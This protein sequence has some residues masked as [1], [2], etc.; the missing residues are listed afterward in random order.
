MRGRNGWR[1]HV[2]V[3]HLQPGWG[4]RCLA[5]VTLLAVL[6]LVACS[7]P[8]NVETEP[9]PL[10]AVSVDSGG[11]TQTFYAPPNTAVSVQLDVGLCSDRPLSID[12]LI[13][14]VIVRQNL[15]VVSWGIDNRVTFT[16]H[17]VVVGPLSALGDFASHRVTQPCPSAGKRFTPVTH[18]GVEL[19]RTSAEPAA[20][21]GVDLLYHV[22]GERR[23]LP[24]FVTV[25]LCASPLRGCKILR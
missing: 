9:D 16:P 6:S 19:V 25:G 14:H 23:Q 22:E 15:Q 2:S 17:E 10:H 3:S 5:V 24:L 8:H 4:R 18:I 7:A 20:L 11:E 21:G 13:P 1:N 12:R